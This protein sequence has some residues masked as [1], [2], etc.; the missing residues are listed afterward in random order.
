MNLPGRNLWIDYVAAI[1]HGSVCEDVRPAGILVNLYYGDV[2][3]C[4]IGKRQ[5]AE[6][7]FGVGYLERWP[8]HVTYIQGNVRE[9]P[10]E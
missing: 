2:Q 5:I 1:I 7:L 4:G 3:L 10:A 6:F 9:V 8:V